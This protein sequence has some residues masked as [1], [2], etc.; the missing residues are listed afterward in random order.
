VLGWTGDKDKSYYDFYNQLFRMANEAFDFKNSYLDRAIQEFNDDKQ[1]D[2][3]IVKGS[4][5]LVDDLEDKDGIFSLFVARNA[6]EVDGNA[7][8]YDK[9]LVADSSFEDSV[10]TTIDILLNK[11]IEKV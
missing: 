7:G 10:K 1:S 9:V 5:E 3:L 11:E 4:D 6:E 8:K 2:I